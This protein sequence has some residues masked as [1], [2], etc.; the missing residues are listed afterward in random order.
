METHFPFFEKYLSN[1][2]LFR[3]SAFNRLI[4]T[5]NSQLS[6]ECVVVIGQ[7]STSTD[8]TSI[9]KGCFGEENLKTL[10]CN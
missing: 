7:G 2:C 8:E 6:V 5:S 3:C 1:T 10:K 9:K 4:L